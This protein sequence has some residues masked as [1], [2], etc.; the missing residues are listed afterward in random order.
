VNEHFILKKIIELIIVSK[1]MKTIKRRK[2]Y[3]EEFDKELQ[4]IKGLRKRMPTNHFE[5][6]HF[7]LPNHSKKD[8]QNVWAQGVMKWDVLVMFGKL[9]NHIPQI[10][11]NMPI[12]ETLRAVLNFE[13]KPMINEKQI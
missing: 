6:V 10:P 11:P 1:P 13:V 5:L 3:K 7:F 4:V 9:V 2:K 12:T 8:I